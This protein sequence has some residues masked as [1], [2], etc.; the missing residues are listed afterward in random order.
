MNFFTQG[1][2]FDH[3]NPREKIDLNRYNNTL[4]KKFL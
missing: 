4:I 1:G 3:E 2:E